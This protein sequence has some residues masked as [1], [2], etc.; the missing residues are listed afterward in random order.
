M[1]T[2]GIIFC[3]KGPI[4][5]YSDNV[6]SRNPSVFAGFVL[7]SGLL[8]VFQGCLFLPKTTN[9]IQTLE[10]R[11]E[12]GN[13]QERL[14]VYL[15]GRRDKAEDFVKQ[16][17]WDELKAQDK[18]FDVVA[19][20]AHLGYYFDQS[21][22]TRLMLDVIEPARQ[23]G[24]KEFWVVGNSLGGLGAMLTEVQQPGTWKGMFLLAPYLGDDKK[25]FESI[26]ETGGLSQWTP[27]YNYKGREFMPKLWEWIRDYAKSPQN[28]PVIFLG[29][30][31]SDRL[32]PEIEYLL[33]ILPDDHVVAMDGGHE[34][35]VWSS[36][37]QVMLKQVGE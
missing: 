9:P 2:N 20:D 21:I 24:Y 36:L 4:R 35:S 14:L 23:Q 1:Y 27:D 15:P 33:P 5:I 34:W 6:K 25:F 26:D 37:W 30:G 32:L 28:N 3:C 29:Y 12:P 18:P 13:R 10:Y 22:V 8:F 11:W 19:V 16:G 7:L 31:N 17:L